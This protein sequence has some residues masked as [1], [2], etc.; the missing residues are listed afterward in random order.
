MLVSHIEVKNRLSM[1]G[2]VSSYTAE[3]FL[4]IRYAINI[5]IL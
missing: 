4:G 2:A 5:K 1:P 3:V